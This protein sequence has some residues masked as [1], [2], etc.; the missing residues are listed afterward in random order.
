MFLVR[1]TNAIISLDG[2]WQVYT[3]FS[4]CLTVSVNSLNL[5][6]IQC[7][8]N[9]FCLWENVHAIHIRQNVLVDRSA[10][11]LLGDTQVMHV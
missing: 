2:E 11:T 6:V 4:K 10:I 3:E 9:Y 5:R 7:I 1:F 8:F